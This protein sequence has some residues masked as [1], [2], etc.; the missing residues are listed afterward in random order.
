MI[1][2]IAGVW[3]SCFL[4]SLPI[5]FWNTRSVLK[6]SRSPQF[7]T[8]NKNL[9]KVGLF[10]SLSSEAFLPRAEKSSEVDVRKALRSYLLIGCLGIFSVIGLLLLIAVS[11]SMHLLVN[12]TAERVFASELA[13]NPDLDVQATQEL[14]SSFS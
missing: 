9:E 14:V 8:L 11:L 7:K 13:K 4:L 12:R 10:W 2:I 3:L 6:K 5:T 1:E